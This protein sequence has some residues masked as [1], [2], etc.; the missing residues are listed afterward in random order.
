[1]GFPSSGGV[2]KPS[3]GTIRIDLYEVARRAGLLN[4]AGKPN[5]KAIQRATDISMPVLWYLLRR[6]ENAQAIR[7]ETLARLCAG[8]QCQPGDI[9]SFTP[10]P[11][12]VEAPISNQ[13][14]EIMDGGDRAW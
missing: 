6:P 5:A 2:T 9:L 7:F 4:L 3:A 1:M 13:W 14:S 11:R 8:L 10:A 12:K